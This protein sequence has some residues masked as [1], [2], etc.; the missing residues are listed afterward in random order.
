MAVVNVK[1][2]QVTNAEAS[3]SVLNNTLVEHG[4]VKASAGFADF[5]ASDATSIARVLTVPSSARVSRLELA[6]DDLGTGGTVDVGLYLA[7]DGAVVDDDLF[8]SAVDTDTAAVARTDI[9]YESAVVGIEKLAMP[10]WEALGLSADPAV[11][12]HVTVTRNAAA[13]TGTVA[14]WLEYVVD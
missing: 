10:L 11:T 5:A 2:A 6:S 13:G 4:R 12:Y 9:T 1:S 3:P 8:A 7:D 14:L